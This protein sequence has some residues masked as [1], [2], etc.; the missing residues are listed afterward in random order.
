VPHKG[1][2]F[3]TIIFLLVSGFARSSNVDSQFHY[4]VNGIVLGGSVDGHTYLEYE[5][6]PSEQFSGFIWCH[7][8]RMETLRVGTVVFNNS[9][10]HDADGKVVYVNKYITPV[11]FGPGEIEKIIS[12]ISVK[13]GEAARVMRLSSPQGDRDALIALWGQISLEQLD[14]SALSIIA[15]GRDVNSGLLVDYLGDFRKSA[16]IALPVYRIAGGPGYLWSA[17]YDRRGRGHQRLLTSN[18]G[19]YV[20]PIESPKRPFQTELTTTQ[21]EVSSLL[22]P[23]TQSDGPENNFLQPSPLTQSVIADSKLTFSNGDADASNQA[24]IGFLAQRLFHWA[25]AITGVVCAIVFGFV[26]NKLLV[27]L[28]VSIKLYEYLNAVGYQVRPNL[29]GK[30]E[31]RRD[32]NE[33]AL[34]DKYQMWN[35]QK[36]WRCNDGYNDLDHRPHDEPWYEVLGVSAEASADEIKSAWHDKIKKN[37][38]DRVAD[39][40]FEFKILADQRTKKLNSARDLGLSNLSTG[41]R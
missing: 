8:R 40:D 17:S 7:N 3:L 5:C 38:P 41:G 26:L 29:C 9:I 15:S 24:S 2:V 4:V 30:Y 6:N 39:L 19:A 13:Y 37:H 35:A 34:H 11:I 33:D 1:T 10:L 20:V 27:N 28:N 12:L 14:S 18:A 21:N 23:V 32:N 36:G 22:K 16:K 31:R 25:A